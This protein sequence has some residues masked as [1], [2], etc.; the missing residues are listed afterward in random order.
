MTFYF[1]DGADT[2]RVREN[3]PIGPN[4]KVI[5]VEYT[6]GLD[7]TFQLT[8]LYDPILGTSVCGVKGRWIDETTF[9]QIVVPTD[10]ITRTV[11]KCHFTDAALTIDVSTM[12][13]GKSTPSIVLTA[14]VI[15]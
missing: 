11:F 10:N 9:E 8:S 3:Q 14:K 12:T 15:D 7:D 6:G 1:T 5:S 2:Y 4:G 13:T